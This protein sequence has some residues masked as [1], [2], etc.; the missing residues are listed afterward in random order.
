MD[1]TQQHL[2]ALGA[3]KGLEQLLTRYDGRGLLV[4]TVAA[5]GWVALPNHVALSP[6]VRDWVV[7]FLGASAVF[8]ILTL[9]LIP[10]VATG[11]TNDVKSFYDVRVR[12]RLF[13]LVGKRW[14]VPWRIMWVCGPQ[15][16][17]F[18]AGIIL[19]VV[20]TIRGSGAGGATAQ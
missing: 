1:R 11:V 14:M 17:L 20:G 4:T 2:T 7:F 19:F 15:H 16:A 9:A 8:G 3:F 6:G 18:L 13:W 12:V 10:H 5:L